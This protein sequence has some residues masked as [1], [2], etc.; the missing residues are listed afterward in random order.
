MITN[1]FLEKSTTLAGKLALLCSI[2]C[3]L[4]LIGQADARAD[5]QIECV[6]CA[7][8][9]TFDN[10]YPR[11]IAVDSLSQPHIVYGKSNLYHAYFDGSQWIVETVDN[12]SGVGSLAAIAIDSADKIHI[13]YPDNTP[14][15][16]ALKRV[17]YATNSSGAWEIDPIDVPSLNNWGKILY[18]SIAVDSQRKA[19]ILYQTNNYD[20]IGLRYLT[21]LSGVWTHINIETNMGG[22]H[23]SIAIDSN[24]KI[25]IAYMDDHE[26]QQITVKYATNAT[27]SGDFE[28]TT[29][30]LHGMGLGDHL[31]MAL[32]SLNN[33]HII[34]GNVYVTWP[35]VYHWELKYATNASGS[36]IIEIVDNVGST[37]HYPSI[38]I[39]QWNN[40]HVAFDGSSG[41]TYAVRTG[42][43][44]WAFS[45]L[46]SEVGSNIS[47]ALDSE[48]KA[49]ISSKGTS[50]GVE[51][52]KYTTNRTGDWI[53][54]VVDK[55]AAMKAGTYSS[56]ALD[57]TGNAHITYYDDDTQGLKYATGTLGNWSHSFLFPPGKKGSQSSIKADASNNL[58]IS[59]YDKDTGAVLY[60]SNKSGGWQTESVTTNNLEDYFVSGISMAM[61]PDNAI[62]M[63]YCVQ[64]RWETSIV[65]LMYATNSSGAWETAQI[66]S[67]CGNTS[68]ALDA[69]NKVHISYT[70]GSN[71]RYATNAGGSWVITPNPAA[72]ANGSLAV[73]SNGASHIS[74]LINTGKTVMVQGV[75]YRVFNLGY[76]TNASGTWVSTKLDGSDTESTGYYSSIAIDPSSNLHISYSDRNGHLKYATNASGSWASTTIA[77]DVSVG[78]LTSIAVD[79]EG[80]IHISFHDGTGAD[81]KYAT[82]AP[83]GTC[84]YYGDADGDGFGDPLAIVQASCGE[85]PAGYVD[86]SADCDDTQAAINAATVWYRDADNDGYSNGDTLTQCAR[87]EGH[88]LSSEL[89]AASGDCDDDNAFLNPTVIWYKDSDGDGYSDGTM[90]MQCAQ[91]AGYQLPADL[92]ATSGDCNDSDPAFILF[93]P[94]VINPHESD[95]DG[96]GTP[97][98]SD[99]ET[100]L[101]GSMTLEAGQYVF[102]NL[103]V[104][105]GAAL[106]LHSNPAL[107]GFKGVKI[108][109]KNLTINSGASFSADAT[110]FTSDLGPGAG[111][112]SESYGGGGAGYGGK[113][114][115]SSGAAGG[116]T[117]GSN[118]SPTDLGSGGGSGTMPGGAGGGAVWIV[119][120]NE[121]IHD[122]AITANGADGQENSGGGSGGS[123]YVTANKII[124]AGS[125]TANGGNASEGGGGGSGRIA[126][127]ADP[128]DFSGPITSAGGTGSN[129]GQQTDPLPPETPSP[130]SVATMTETTSQSDVLSETVVHN[131]AILNNVAVTGD[132]SGNLNFTKLDFFQITT[133][134]FAGKGFSRG[135]WTATLDEI[136]YTG[137]WQ[138]MFFKKA[139]AGKLYLKGTISGE[140]SGI[141]DGFL[142]ELNPGSDVFDQYQAIWKIN[143]LK[144]Q[145]TYANLNLAGV[146]SYPQNTE[147][148]DSEIYALQTSIDG[149]TSGYYSQPLGIVLTHLKVLRADVPFY[150]EGFSILSYTSTKG[151]GEGWAYN[152]LAGYDIPELT[153]FMT[154]PFDGK[155]KGVLYDTGTPRILNLEIERMDLGLP[156]LSDLEVN[157]LAPNDVSSGETIDYL[158]EHRNQGI[159]NA[160]HVLVVAA[161][162]REVKYI[163]SG[164]NGIYIP[165]MHKVYWL[166]STVAANSKG[167]LSFRG[168][169]SF[170]L[171]LGTSLNAAALIGTADGNELDAYLNPARIIPF[172]EE[173]YESLILNKTLSLPWDDGTLH[174][175]EVADSDPVIDFPIPKKNILRVIDNIRTY[176]KHR[177]DILQSKLEKLPIVGSQLKIVWNDNRA[178][179]YWGLTN[180]IYIN[181]IVDGVDLFKDFDIYDESP[182]LHR[183]T[184]SVLDTLSGLLLHEQFHNE[185]FASIVISFDSNDWAERAAYSYEIKFYLTRLLQEIDNEC[186]ATTQRHEYLL[187]NIEN[188]ISG[189]LTE[190][191]IVGGTFQ[192]KYNYLYSLYTNGDCDEMKANVEEFIDYADSVIAQNSWFA[193]QKKNASDTKSS[194]I[195][196]HDPNAKYI[197]YGDEYTMEGKSFYPGD[198]LPFKV[199]FENVGEGK[200]FGVYFTDT[201]DQDLDD[202]TL[203]IGPV[204]SVCKE[205]GCVPDQIGD[206]GAYNPQ[207]RT[208]TWTIWDEGRVDP[209]N[210]GFAE[211]SINAKSDLPDGTEITNYATVYFPSVPEVTKTNGI[212]SVVCS[213][214]ETMWFKDEDDDGYSDDTFVTQCLRPFGYKLEGELASTSGDCDDTNKDINP[215]G[216]WFKD[217]DNDGYSN[218]DM[219]AQCERP[220]GYKPAAELTAASGDCDDTNA[221]IHPATVWY[222]DDDGD[223][224]STGMT[225]TQCDAPGGYTLPGELIATSGDC[226]DYNADVH[227]AT[228]WYQDSDND[229]FSTGET[230]TQ[231]PRPDG[232]KL[233]G[234]LLAASGECRDD[235]PAINPGAQEVCGDG[236]D[237]NCNGQADEGC[238]TSVS[239]S[240]GAFFYPE[241]TSYKASFSMDATGPV[242]PSGWLKYYYARTRMNFVST[243]ITSLSV[244]G[245]TATISGTGTVN[246]AGAYAF[247]A[248]VRN[249]F[250]DTFAIE[251]KKANGAVHYSAG[252][253]N[254]GGGDLVIR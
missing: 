95:L 129:N 204:Y 132:L 101:S 173:W 119:I 100:V 122:G 127:Y 139:S 146:L 113:G 220:E 197:K 125:F 242:F 241:S 196:G 33:P 120:E 111:Q 86:N 185:Q 143:K 87:P 183:D 218:G 149:N 135:T 116:N 70:G 1:A 43:G 236:M 200:A 52:V 59:Y 75:G 14:T 20:Q 44:A 176:D 214:P 190:D 209:K 107:S 24:D 148:P 46:P 201:L 126:V 112:A 3:L 93:C 2:A 114:G 249:G 5:W 244:S 210:G 243:A 246:G 31:T 194:L 169:T 117:Y 106:A 239:V 35:D 15:G 74:Y 26:Y 207:T 45:G 205:E 23:G 136:S 61:D 36:W 54:T 144:N 47:L 154:A 62:Y 41:R 229:G 192:S 91:P 193:P 71:V 208:I 22:N 98:I 156:A 165:E 108:T 39:D 171:G 94:N 4:A 78:P 18:T 198:R 203:E 29:V 102:R 254:I 140:I 248:K 141:V 69:N 32:D 118:V 66:D 49:H 7:G 253:K 164:N 67:S 85:P 230:L 216:E 48:G 105:E 92:T 88:K 168:K 21:N 83:A 191:A 42:P 50:G 123:I 251:I 104:Q 96:D 6:D 131:P 60:A 128:S 81:L 115:D 245:N 38:A 97:D 152:R 13:A 180:K 19:H 226:D 124:G 110:G 184:Q 84:S 234:E 137:E 34:Y 121:M 225:Q 231:C 58:H 247:T 99:E 11:S 72:G 109:A 161:I 65:M 182:V 158:I 68:I 142:T 162:P 28:I 233:L 82:N 235:D 27:L 55:A 189:L 206:T 237:N 130:Q 178:G 138:G 163:Q 199:E 167:Y 133:G 222:Q 77:S 155:L 145:G 223:G 195:T 79:T 10:F 73:D 177:A 9:K 221:D 134:L 151:S 159:Q 57:P 187:K 30:D 76:L 250:P 219:Q 172:T 51:A 202:A 103:I 37:G 40:I 228:V 16:V 188:A 80:F 211:Y 53:T 215:E 227:P 12:Y 166:I 252:P 179:Y 90:T 175:V 8:A 25:H 170:G 181:Q 186:P 63:S 160:E 213:N 17:R 232:Y 224:Y 56:L 64:D 89:T 147:Y 240:G 157:I 153:G 217:E 174:E 150:G 212:T 238:V